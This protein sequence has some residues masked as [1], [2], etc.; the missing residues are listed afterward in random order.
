LRPDLRGFSLV[1]ILLATV[2]LAIVASTIMG[3]VATA[4]RARS[5]DETRVAMAHAGDALRAALRNYTVAWPQG[6][7]P[8]EQDLA[9][10]DT[11]LVGVAGCTSG[12]RRLPG[13]SCPWALALTCAHDATSM[14]PSSLSGHP[15]NARM[16]YVVKEAAD[17]SRSVDISV[18]WQRP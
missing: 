18:T 13:D 7:E 17:F 10:L 8:R 5:E 9:E 1:E 4:H 16:T 11:A 14:L 12:C 6:G 3:V 15:K 2:A